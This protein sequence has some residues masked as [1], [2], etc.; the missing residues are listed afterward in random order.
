[1]PFSG[2]E[3]DILPFVGTNK[4]GAY[5][6]NAPLGVI[7][8][9][10][11]SAIA[12][13]VDYSDQ[14]ISAKLTAATI[15]YQL[16]LARIGD[17]SGQL[18]IQAFLIT[19]DGDIT[20]TSSKLGDELVYDLSK[21]QEVFD[22]DVVLSSEQLT[23]I[24]E[25]QLKIA[26]KVS[27]SLR[28]LTAGEVGLSYE[29]QKLSLKNIKLAIDE[30]LPNKNG[31]IAD[32]SDADKITP[33]VVGL[34][35]D[36]L[37][38]LIHNGDFAGKVSVQIFLAPVDETDVFQEKYKFGSAQDIDLSKNA[39]DIKANASINQLQLAAARK[40]QKLKYAMQI[41]GDVGINKGGK[42][43]FDYKIKKLD[44]T[45]YFTIL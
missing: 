10:T 18:K 29:L 7:P 25:K 9:L 26:F 39:Q 19:T 32:F 8:F 30:K 14:T 40:D 33:Q 17:I 4:T 42:I 24:N 5:K 3:F 12:I 22:R 28:V 21:T 43:R 36:Y 27:G 6:F 41:I 2:G 37:L 20:A 23:A 15:S 35:L 45:A 11:L 44:L 13:P 16:K 34:R 1:M 31:E 38:E